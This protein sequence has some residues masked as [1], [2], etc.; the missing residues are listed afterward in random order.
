MLAVCV[1]LE[2]TLGTTKDLLTRAGH[3]FGTSEKYQI[4]SFL[5]TDFRGQSIDEC[6][7]FLMEMKLPPLG[8]N[9]RNI[10]N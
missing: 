3:A 2:L 8:S 1:G 7:D 9:E 4:Y 5:F 6:N 10:K